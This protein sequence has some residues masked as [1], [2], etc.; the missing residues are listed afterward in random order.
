LEKFVSYEDIP[1]IVITRGLKPPQVLIDLAN[2]AG[3]PILNSD[4]LLLAL[5]A[6]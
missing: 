2:E 4:I 5:S 1:C 6:G 3:I